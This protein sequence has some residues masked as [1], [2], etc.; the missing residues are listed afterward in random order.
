M[1]R[2]LAGALCL[3]VITVFALLVWPEASY[4]RYEPDAAYLEQAASYP[5]PPMP[6]DW[7]QQV[8]EAADGTVLRWGETGN[9]DSA[10]AT[11]LWVPG[12]TATLD[13]YGEQIDRL[14]ERGYHVVGLDLRGQ[15]LSERARPEQPEKLSIDD[16]A[17][18]SIDV[19]GF[20]RDV[21]PADRPVI[22][23]AMSFGGHVAFRTALQEP[24]LFDAVFLV[25]PALRPRMGENPDAAVA[26]MRLMR[27]LGKAQRYVPGQGGWT[28]TMPDMSVAG[29][30]YCAS[31]PRRLH[32]R[33]VV[34]TRNPQQRVGGVTAQWG[35][36]FVESANWIAASPAVDALDVP[37]RM[38]LADYE[39]F[40][41]NDVNTAICGR[42][43][44]CEAVVLPDT[45][46]CL[47]QETDAVLTRMYDA[48]DALAETLR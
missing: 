5:L 31:E 6:D 4:E 17:V 23:V 42:L 16:F 26:V 8:W 45:A 32:A 33:D 1:S 9:R 29:P 40:V 46:H 30:E 18:Y 38:M 14:A 10:K 24:E 27:L 12:Y 39:V 19:A 11:I 37:V 34:Y 25:A 48:L 21:V 22:P 28:V 47:T 44:A 36:E 35:L 2:I 7:R 41:E 13:M 43:P 3:L 15:G 20:T